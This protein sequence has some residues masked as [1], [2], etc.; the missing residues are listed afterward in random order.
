MARSV[1][2]ILRTASLMLELSGNGRPNMRCASK[3]RSAYSAL[4]MC[5][6][7]SSRRISD[8]IILEKRT[9]YIGTETGGVCRI[10]FETPRKYLLTPGGGTLVFKEVQ[11][12]PH[13]NRCVS[14]EV[15]E[16]KS[17][18]TDRKCNAA[19]M[20]QPPTP[21]TCIRLIDHSPLESSPVVNLDVSYR[22]QQWLASYPARSPALP[23]LPFAS[24][25]S[26]SCLLVCQVVQQL[27]I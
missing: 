8:G 4:A 1:F 24:V 7:F 3:N 22:L 10:E 2:F 14:S 27:P 20:L 21:S 9:D 25:L 23:I 19:M 5:S 15:R 17:R 18:G 12:G 16:M 6:R 26:L 11:A 13:W